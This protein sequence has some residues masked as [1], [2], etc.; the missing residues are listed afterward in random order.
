MRGIEVLLI[1]SQPRLS[2]WKPAMA[3]GRDGSL[4]FRSNGTQI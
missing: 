3:H 1:A 4:V 2:G